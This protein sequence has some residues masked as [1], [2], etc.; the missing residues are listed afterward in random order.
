MDNSTQIASYWN[1]HPPLPAPAPA[2]DGEPQAILSSCDAKRLTELGLLRYAPAGFCRIS[3]DIMH[4][5]THP[6]K[7]NNQNKY[8]G[9]WRKLPPELQLA[10]MDVCRDEEI[11][12]LARTSRKTRTLAKAIVKKRQERFA[13]LP[14]TD[15]GLATLKYLGYTDWKAIEL[16]ADWEFRGFLDETDFLAHCLSPLSLWSINGE[17]RVDALDDSDDWR[18]V[19][20]HWGVSKECQD[21]ILDPAFSDIRLT[22]SAAYWVCKTIELRWSTLRYIQRASW[23]RANPR[24]ILRVRPGLLEQPPGPHRYYRQFQ[25]QQEKEVDMTVL[26]KAIDV[27][28]AY[29]VFMSGLKPSLSLFT[30]LQQEDEEWTVDFSCWDVPFTLYP[31]RLLAEKFA[32]YSARRSCGYSPAVLLKVCITTKALKDKLK[33]KTFGDGEEKG[34]EEEWKK[35]VWINR[36]EEDPADDVENGVPN[37]VADMWGLNLVVGKVS[38]NKGKAIVKMASWEEISGDNV[39]VVD[40]GGGLEA[41]V[42]Y[43]FLGDDC[44]RELDMHARLEMVHVRGCEGR[45]K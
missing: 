44:F 11:V 39:L 25:R 29:N 16:W 9:L 26:Y 4:A 12:S 20:S 28:T 19:M 38:C 8:F 21:A 43:S 6:K 36:M 45:M 14:L 2:E 41:A 5:T 17:E 1:V 10:I 31:S 15:Q 22:E 27:W 37:P 7:F 33:I 42:Q 32:R 30:L 18:A 13:H 40:G 3:L 35:V 24:K 34:N 23:H